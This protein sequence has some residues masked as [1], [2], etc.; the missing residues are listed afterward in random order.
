MKCPFATEMAEKEKKNL[1]N[2]IA[3]SQISKWGQYRKVYSKYKRIHK[4]V[5]DGSC[6]IYGV[7]PWKLCANCNTMEDAISA[8]H[9]VCGAI[10]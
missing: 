1:A 9:C 4:L 5:N 10:Y 2:N 6:Q 3:M 8:A 7:C